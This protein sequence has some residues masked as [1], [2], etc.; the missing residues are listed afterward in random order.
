MSEK[1]IPLSVPYL[2][3]N[4]LKFITTVIKAGWAFT[5][6]SYVNEFEEN[7]RENLSLLLFLENIRNSFWFCGMYCHAAYLLNR[8]ERMEKRTGHEI[9]TCSIW[10]LISEQ[11]PYKNNKSFQ[12][13]KAKHYGRYAVN[14]LC[15]VSLTSENISHIYRILRK[16]WEYGN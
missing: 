10:E 11:L 14:I 2:R 13:T 9:Q 12:I 5:G 6:G 7:Y 16:G 1:F 3:E 15:S 8:N 4:E